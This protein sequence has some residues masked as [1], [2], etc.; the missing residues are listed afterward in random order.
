MNSYINSTD[1]FK[2]NNPEAIAS[3]YGTPVYV[4]NEEIIRKSMETVE[5]V[6]TKYP[7]TANYS[8]KANTNI[9]I[10]KLALEEGLNCDAMSPGEITL[11][12]KAG[13]PPEKIFFVSNNVAAEEMQFA[14]DKG[15]MVSLD[16]LDQLDRFGQINPGGRCAVRINPGVGAGHSEK[17][18]TAGKKT[19]FAI[20]EEDIDKIFEIADKYDLKIVGINQHIG[21]GF[22]DPKP[23]IDAVT[24][25]LRIA[26]RFDNLEFIDFGG[27]YGIPY[28]KLDDEKPFPM[29]DFKVKLEPVLD[30]FVQRYGKTPLF[31]SEPGRYCVAEGSVIL[32]RVQ[33]IK[34]NAGIKYVGCDTG[35]NTLIRPAMYDSYHDIEVI[36]DGK[37]VDRDGNNDMETVNV[38][39]PICETGDLIAKERL[40][41]K[42]KTG[43][44]LAILDTGAYGYA[45]ASSYNSRPRPAEVMITKEGKVVQ[46]RR[47]ETIE[48]LLS[49]F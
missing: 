10:L 33:A 8:V 44:L 18:I 19:K 22:L 20:A 36:R 26:D 6:I 25:L 35:M 31:K 32:S 34:T 16:S 9:E 29:E 7:Y 37:V 23:Y 15:V 1:F 38:S 49:L 41:P 28:H 47:R 12:L 11:L 3:E 48:D 21:S 42:A 27:G 14:I 43:D 40:L 30:E 45:M 46:I 5:G 4:Y 2:G 13:F 24:N 39:G 17:V